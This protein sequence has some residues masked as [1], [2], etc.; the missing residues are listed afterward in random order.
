MLFIYGDQLSHISAQG[1]FLRNLFRMLRKA[2]G[3]PCAF[4]LSQVNDRD[5]CNID[6]EYPVYNTFCELSYGV[7]NCRVLLIYTYFN[8]GKRSQG[9]CFAF[10]LRAI[11]NKTFPIFI[12]TNIK[13]IVFNQK[14]VC[15]KTIVVVSKTTSFFTT[16]A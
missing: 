7:S 13:F 9:Q 8:S 2:R 11:F 1:T 3:F 4:E 15:S 10:M 12:S 14:P 16:T 6:I 5:T